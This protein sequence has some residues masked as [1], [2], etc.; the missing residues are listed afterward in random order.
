M[1]SSIAA[2]LERTISAL[3]L[4]PVACQSGSMDPVHTAHLFRA[5]TSKTDKPV[6]GHPCNMQ[7]SKVG[8]S[9]RRMGANEAIHAIAQR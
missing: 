3:T 8:Y 9:S 2:L 5:F 1:V 6:G 7:R 4:V